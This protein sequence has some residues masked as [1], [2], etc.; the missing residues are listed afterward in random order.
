MQGLRGERGSGGDIRVSRQVREQLEN[1]WGGC[2][3]LMQTEVSNTVSTM[4]QPM[5]LRS[6]TRTVKGAQMKDGCSWATD[7]KGR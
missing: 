1:R 4:F 5:V 6:P 3:M 7:G 2:G